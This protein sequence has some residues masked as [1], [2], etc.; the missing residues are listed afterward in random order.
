MT[1]EQLRTS[2]G[3]FTA[4]LLAGFDDYLA[5]PDVDLAHDAVGFRTAAIHLR[6]DEVAEL[7]ERLRAAVEP[8]TSPRPGVRRHLFSTV[9]APA[10]ETG[11]PGAAPAT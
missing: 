9:L 5:G 6:E 4:S 3:V 2:F 10:P 8:W 1:H 7:T 11:A